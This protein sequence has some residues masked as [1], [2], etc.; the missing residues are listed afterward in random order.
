MDFD[1]KFDE[2]PI[3]E[4]GDCKGLV[5]RGYRN[6]YFHKGTYEI[7]QGIRLLKRKSCPGCE[8]CDWM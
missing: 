6:E 1:F 5:F 3:D 8:H 7:K 4:L 2:E